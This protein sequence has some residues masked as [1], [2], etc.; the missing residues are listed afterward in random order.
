MVKRIAAGL[1]G[2]GLIGGVGAVTYG[3]DGTATVTIEDHGT[4]HTVTLPMEVGGKSYSCPSATQDKISSY[5]V[6]AG[7]I[8]LTLQQVRRQ[9][10]VIDK[11]HP[12]RT[13]PKAVARRYN[14]LLRRD[15]DLVDRFNSAVD[16]RNA[17][18]RTDCT[19]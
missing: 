14:K 7:R 4:K 15:D 18:L 16:D 1:V 11:R 19:S 6:N 5:D 10:K 12:G 13:A 17:I 9:E 8:K 2:V 3:D